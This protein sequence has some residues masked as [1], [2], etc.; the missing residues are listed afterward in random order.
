MGA[1]VKMIEELH[2]PENAVCLIS[3]TFVQARLFVEAKVIAKIDMIDPHPDL[4]QAKHFVIPGL[5][6]TH[7]HLTACTANL[8]ALTRMTPSLVNIAAAE[9]LRQTLRRGF[10]TVRDAGG[11]DCGLA[12]A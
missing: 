9:E 2:L 1:V 6:D 11:A 3:G 7:V 5:I 12:D 10:T 4:S 8:A